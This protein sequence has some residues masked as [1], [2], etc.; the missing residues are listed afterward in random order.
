MLT[1][2]MGPGVMRSH[3]EELF[4]VRTVLWKKSTAGKGLKP[5]K[6]YKFLFTIQIPMIQFPPSMNHD[7]YRCIYKLSAYLDPSLGHGE[8]P[9]MS[10]IHIKYIP[11]IETKLLKTPIF[12]QDQ[13]AKNGVS[14]A[15]VKLYSIEYVAGSTI[16][17]TVCITKKLKNVAHSSYLSP[18]RLGENVHITL[19]LFQLSKFNLDAEPILTE[20]VATQ[21]YGIAS[22]PDDFDNNNTREYHVSMKVN[23]SLPPTFEYSSIMSLTY[24]LKIK[25][26]LK[27]SKNTPSTDF[28]GS[29]AF[30]DSTVTVV[31]TDHTK[32]ENS[33]KVSR[34]RNLKELLTKPWSG[35]ESVFESPIII[36]TLDRGIRTGD[37]LKSYSDFHVDSGDQM[38][39]PRFMKNI[40]YGDA[41]PKYEPSRLPLYGDPTSR[42][43]LNDCHERRSN[44]GSIVSS[45]VI[46]TNT[47][48]ITSVRSLI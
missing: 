46:T 9:V 8:V 7:Y 28:R 12:L 14:T 4:S 13:K 21:S 16:R 15:L 5:R 6:T 30:N 18:P 32:K 36:G 23:E 29:T 22:K 37:E 20:L 43:I 3:T 27:K 19:S 34:T 48:S 33:N 42:A 26:H 24:K 31:S 39:R 35:A 47:P 41:L 25:I 44:R 10:Q 1:Y 11:L 2:E 40:E 45:I 17:A 38:P